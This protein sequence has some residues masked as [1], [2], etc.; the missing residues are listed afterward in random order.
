MPFPLILL[1]AL[2]VLA[3]PAADAGA[4][5]YKNTSSISV[6]FGQG[7]ETPYIL[8]TADLDGDGWEDFALSGKVRV[9]AA[10]TLQQ[11]GQIASFVALNDRGARA[12]RLYGLGAAGMTHRTWAGK[13]VAA[14][15]GRTFLFLGRNGEIGLPHTLTGEPTSVFQIAGNAQGLGIATVRSAGKRTT[16]ASIAACALGGGGRQ[17]VFVNNVNSPFIQNQ[18][19]LQAEAFVAG[20]GVSDAS[21]R[22]MVGGMDNNG[23]H[24]FVE[25]ADA[26]GDGD[27]DFLAAFEVWKVGGANEAYENRN[28]NN[29]MHS[30]V[31]LN[32]GGKFRSRI[33]LPGPPFGSNNSA[34]GI[35]AGK[36]GQTPVVAL[37]SSEFR[38]H[39]E[40]FSKFAFQLFAWQGG[41]FLDV[42][43]SALSGRIS[44]RTAN[45]SFVK[46]KDIDGDGDDDIYLTRYDSGIK[47]YLQE[48]GKLV[49]RSISAGGRG[50]RAVAF[51]SGPGGSCADVVVL[52]SGGTLSRYEC[53]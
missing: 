29:S 30:Y 48:N 5:G 53:R 24:N 12:V 11:A 3:S 37:T 33:D 6:P 8:D 52:D 15:K 42:S 10:K 25:F 44:N 41:R 47:V 50:E 14:G 46:F 45:Q 16:T 2:F 18:E 20:S 19:F 40:G 9:G 43:G 51:L 26:D 22:A 1:A 32:S 38:G 28:R 17:S 21:P 13:F 4:P 35:G 7:I 36:L 31:L 34:F 23:A 49:S 39:K 27:C